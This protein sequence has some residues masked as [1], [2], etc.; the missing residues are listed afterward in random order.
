[1]IK[2]HDKKN[3]PLKGKLVTLKPLQEKFFEE[4]H[5]MFSPIVRQALGLPPTCDMQETIKYLQVALVDKHHHMVYCIFENK[6]NK[7]IGGIV[8]RSK[9]HPNGQ[10]GSWL[11]EHFWG[12][13]RY[14]EALYLTLKKYFEETQDNSIFAFVTEENKRSL[15]AHQKFGF[16]VAKKLDNDHRPGK[17]AY[18]IELTRNKFEQKRKNFK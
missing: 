7:L 13:G 14:Q 2:K 17:Y 15:K 12:S 8:I 16:V 18:L 6:T 1:M 3:D 4:Y 10:L 11:N 5:R 9:E